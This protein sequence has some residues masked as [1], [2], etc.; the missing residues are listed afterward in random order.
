MTNADFIEIS[1]HIV[2]LVYMSENMS[3]KPDDV[4]LAVR[5]ET[6][7]LAEETLRSCTQMG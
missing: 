1:K 7:R 3:V 6:Q 5:I 2:L 4:V